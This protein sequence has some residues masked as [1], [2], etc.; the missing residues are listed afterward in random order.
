MSEYLENFINEKI[1]SL[2]CAEANRVLLDDD[3]KVFICDYINNR[4]SHKKGGFFLQGPPVSLVQSI[5]EQK[6]KGLIDKK[7]DDAVEKIFRKRWKEIQE[8]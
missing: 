2:I 5:L 8:G 1:E 7:A 6:I 4:Y 3:L